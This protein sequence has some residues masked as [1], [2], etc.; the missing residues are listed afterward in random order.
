[1][2]PIQIA[3]IIVSFSWVYHGLFPKLVHIAPLEKQM[4]AS[5]GFSAE[6]SY[7]VTKEAGVG[8]M[9]YGTTLFFL[10]TQASSCSKYSG[11]SWFIGVCCHYAAAAVN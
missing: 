9:L 10:S 7:L 4:T 8:E 11:L 1:M 2:Q 5:F 3:R 6:H